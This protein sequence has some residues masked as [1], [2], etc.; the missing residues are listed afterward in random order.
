MNERLNSIFREYYADKLF[1]D[2]FATQPAA[3]V[4]V[5]IPVIHTNELWQ[6]NLFSFYREIPIHA[7]LIG[8]GGCID[9]SIEIAQTFP[10]V[11][12]L[13]H[14]GY[15]SLGYSIRKLIES[16]E[17]DWFIYIHSDAYVPPGWF[18]AM[19][20][21]QAEYDWF[22]CPMRH[23]VMVEYSGEY[24][25]RPWA[26]SQMGRKRVFEAGLRRIDDDYVYRQ[27]D[28]VFSDIVKRGGGKE[29]R[30]TNTFHYHQTM[31]KPTPWSRKVRS[32]QI[33]V[34]MSREEEARA[35]MMQGKGIVKYLQPDGHWVINDAVASVHH[36]L[37]MGE[38]DW[39]EF[40]QW[41]RKTNPVWLPYLRKGLFT[42]RLKD[43][44]RSL[45]RSV[46]RRVFG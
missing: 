30:V 27:E 37:E 3:A 8:D 41:V 35:C 4:D 21:H 9:D 1:I 29:G 38:L 12:V 34:E 16:V 28:F 42:M 14:S 25:E 32:V 10:R 44:L 2:R 33:D 13:D 20:K 40:E 6:A 46:A 5:I 43:R 11:Q 23:T 39:K 19:Q 7:L 31:R 15:K 45:L 36:L 24:G 26:G 17:T 22:G 18:D